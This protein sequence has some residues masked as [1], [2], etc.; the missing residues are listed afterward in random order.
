LHFDHCGGSIQW[1]KDKTGYEPAFK[2]LNFGPTKITGIGTKPNVRETSF[3]SENIL[4]ES[5]QLHFI[6]DLKV[7]F[8]K[9]RTGF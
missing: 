6:K 1:N 8:L 3:L 5:G 7:I 4:Q 2:M 9:I